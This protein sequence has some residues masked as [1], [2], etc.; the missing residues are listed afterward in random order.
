MNSGTVDVTNDE[1][2][3]ETFF[4][5]E[6]DVLSM[7][8]TRSTSPNDT[9]PGPDYFVGNVVDEKTIEGVWYRPISECSYGECVPTTGEFEVVLFRD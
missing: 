9:D 1:T 7:G 5:L 2:E 4:E 3:T 8:W 6:G